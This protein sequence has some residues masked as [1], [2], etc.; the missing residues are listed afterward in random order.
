VALG[1]YDGDGKEDLLRQNDLT[2]RL[3]V[4]FMNGLSLRDDQCY[5]LNPDGFE[6]PQQEEWFVVGPR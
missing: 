6:R 2:G 4:C 5:A 3:Q 1:D